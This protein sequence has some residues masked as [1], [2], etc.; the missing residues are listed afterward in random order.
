MVESQI[1]SSKDNTFLY[2]LIGI[3]I[4][5]LLFVAFF[6]FKSNSGKFADTFTDPPDTPHE[7]APPLVEQTGLSVTVPH[8]FEAPTNVPVPNYAENS[9]EARLHN[10]N[11]ETNH[12]N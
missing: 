11:H 3:V 5:G 4:L 9:V 10:E 7:D 2:I 1:K 8:D 6:L 12:T